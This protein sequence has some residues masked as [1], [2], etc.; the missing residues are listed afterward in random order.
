MKSLIIILSAG[1]TFGLISCND[2]SDTSR[3]DADSTA[4]TASAPAAE[5]T[6][7]A[8]NDVA[9]AEVEVP[10][11]TKTTFET[12]YPKAT[13]VKW[14]RYQRPEGVTVDN[15]D[16]NSKLD[17]ND[18]EVAFTFNDVDYFAWYDDGTWL[19]SRTT[20]KDPNG[21]PAAINSTIKKEFPGF[22]VVE[23]DKEEYGKNDHL[24]EVELKKGDEKY[25]AHF[26]ENG[27]MT[28]K[29]PKK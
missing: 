25:K 11:T 24:Y 2:D 14:R 15:S 10:A 12:K 17:S 5:T 27:K 26:T 7:P 13:N 20:V 4:A 18:Y 9:T 6:T 16:W 1:L 19:R 21:L 22:E 28:K 8:T 29:Q 3:S 23:V